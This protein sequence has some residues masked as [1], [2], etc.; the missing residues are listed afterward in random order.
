MAAPPAPDPRTLERALRLLAPLERAFR[1]ELTGVERIPRGPGPLMFVG[2]HQLLAF[3]SP[4]LVAQIWRTYGVPLRPLVDDWLF[5]TALLGRLVESLGAVQASR[6]HANT[7]L[8][9]DAWILVY[10][11][12]ARE[13]IKSDG[14][15]YGLSWFD[16]LGFAAMALQHQCTIVPV[17]ARGVDSSFS[18]LLSAD[19]ILASPL[20]PV[21]DRLHVRRDL[22]MPVVVPRRWPHLRFRLCEP[23]RIDHFLGHDPQTSQRRLRAEVAGALERGLAEME[24]H[25]GPHAPQVRGPRRR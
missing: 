22:V 5:M 12:G 21:L 9:Q 10:P 4:F 14:H 25:P 11:G 8:R 20:G 24:L 3:D 1:A 16:R 17:A 13:A 23:I 7:L 6:E 18:V 19:R 15:R 2:N